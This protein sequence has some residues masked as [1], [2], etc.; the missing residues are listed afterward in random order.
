VRRFFDA[1]APQALVLL[2]T[3]LWPN[4]L[5]E[6]KRRQVPV[7]LVNGRL[8]ERTAVRMRWP[9][10][11][12]LFREAAGA[13]T[14]AGM[15]NEAHAGRLAGLGVAR[16]RLRVTGNMKFDSA[17]PPEADR[18]ATL[19][20]EL[21]LAGAGPVVVFGNS[22]PGEEALFEGVMRELRRD[23]PAAVGIAAPR[24]LARRDEALAALGEE[25]ELLTSLRRTGSA[26]RSP[27]VLADTMGELDALY[28]CADVAIVGGS[29]Y[30]GVGGHNPLEPAA[31]GAATL[32]GPFMHNNADAA[33]GLV[34]A[35]GAAQVEGPEELYPVLAGLIG[36]KDARERMSQR[37]LGVIEVNRGA[38]DRNLRL[39]LEAIG[40]TDEA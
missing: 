39:I 11:R 8:S 28:A 15:Q 17:A 24:H 9:G 32:F 31:A 29:F 22:R 25:T 1:A 38:T 26:R 18:V 6:A 33:S 4:C 34:E 23:W 36:D 2:E 35:G 13:L 37:G 14:V 21:A 10:F 19:M 7:V 30:E 40:P 5:L 3:E 20:R 12:A 16:E 27:L